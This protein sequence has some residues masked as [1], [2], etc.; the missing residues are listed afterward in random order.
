MEKIPSFSKNHDEL[1]TGLHICGISHGVTTW[2]LRFKKPNAGDYITPKALH[3]IEH[4]LATVLR[5]SAEK[6]NIIYFGP[7]GC[8]TG[9]YLLTTNLDFDRTLELLKESLALS[10][11]LTEVPGNKREECGNYLEHDLQ[12]AKN[13][14]K[15]Y[16]EILNNIN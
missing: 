7:M 8:R 10:L 4:L 13:E 9:F 1:K 2:D 14:C 11:E 5:N 6:D 3:T 12:D 15:K 16:L